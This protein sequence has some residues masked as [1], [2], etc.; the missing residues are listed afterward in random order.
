MVSVIDYELLLH[1]VLFLHCAFWSLLIINTNKCTFL[2]LWSLKFTLKHLKCSYMF[3]S[4]DHPPGAYIVPCESYILE[5]SVNYF[6][7]STWWC[8]SMSCV[9]MCVVP[10]AE[11]KTQTHTNTRHAATSPCWYNEV[12]HWLF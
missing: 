1:N 10:C 2:Y 4:S 9:C 5:Q 6:I 7:I 11:R 12:I 8:D 3:W